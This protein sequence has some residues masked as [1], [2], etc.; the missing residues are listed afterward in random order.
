M[1][2]FLVQFFGKS[3][4]GQDEQS[5]QLPTSDQFACNCWCSQSFERAQT[6]YFVIQIQPL[7]LYDIDGLALD[8][9][10]SSA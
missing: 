6:D 4:F 3:S 8:C 2:N 10:N 9:S 7:L 5:Y 1:N